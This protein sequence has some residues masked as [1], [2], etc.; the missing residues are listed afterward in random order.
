MPEEAE[1]PNVTDFQMYYAILNALNKEPGW[2]EGVS[3]IYYCLAQDYLYKTPKNHVTFLDNHDLS[4]FYSQVGND[5]EKYKMGIG[6]LMTLRGIQQ[7]YYGTEILMD[8]F[9]NPDGLVRQD[10]PGG[11]PEDK[12]NKFDEEQRTEM[13]NS[14][15]NYV[16]LLA[17]YRKNSV[18]L[19][20]GELMQFIPENGVYTFFRYRKEGTV[21]VMINTSNKKKFLNAD[22]Y[23][24][25]TKGFVNGKDIITGKGEKIRGDISI[26]P[27][28]IKIIE[29]KK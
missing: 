15:Y 9:S 3:E 21:M 2:N 6:L 26:S 18:V 23:D 17:N 13:E 4:R 25:M 24:E 27:K 29:L 20:E 12:V 7:L 1:L 16:K 14:A 28:T 5:F 10:F 22:K 11:W 19:Q 8:G